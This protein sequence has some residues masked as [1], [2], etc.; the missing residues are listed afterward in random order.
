M[1]ERAGRAGWYRE[2]GDEPPDSPG[3][4]EPRGAD[5]WDGCSR[6]H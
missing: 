2:N 6:H 5:A 1:G 3:L 4:P